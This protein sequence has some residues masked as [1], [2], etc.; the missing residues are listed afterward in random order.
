[1]FR[2]TLLAAGIAAFVS[3]GA[4]A[5]VSPDEA[6]QLGTTLTPV[7][8]EKAGNKDSTIPAYTGGLTTPPASYQKGSKV[9]TD[10]SL[11]RSLDWSSPARTSTRMRTS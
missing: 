11:T 10:R 3:A 7:G 2:R 9:R 4:S 6:K 5:G 1:M 8:A